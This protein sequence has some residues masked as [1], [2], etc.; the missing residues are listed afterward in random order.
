MVFDSFQGR[1]FAT[2]H[3]S[4]RIFTRIEI[5]GGLSL[6]KPKIPIGDQFLKRKIR[7]IEILLAQKFISEGHCFGPSGAG[8]F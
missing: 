8:Q 5:I 6:S 2:Y 4:V 3:H 7:E 1:L